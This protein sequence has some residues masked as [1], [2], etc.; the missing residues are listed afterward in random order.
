MIGRPN[1]GNYN[2]YFKAYID[3]VPGDDI[4]LKM[5]NKTPLEVYKKISTE[6]WAYRYAEGKWSIKEM[7]M[8]VIDAERIFAYRA[9]RI[10]RGDQTAL[11][12]FDQNE[13]V[14]SYRAAHRSI[15][16]LLEEYISTRQSS[17][18][19]FENFDK[20]H[21]MQIGIAGDSKTS[22]LSLAFMIVGHELHHLQLMKDKYHI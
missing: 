21:F 1:S 20:D 5:G 12:G 4:L 17:L 22:V 10:S 8:H 6:K 15:E 16:S 7:M 9:L 19:M 2:P 11:P 14:P 3:K 18:K 13:Y